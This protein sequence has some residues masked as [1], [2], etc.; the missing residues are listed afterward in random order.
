M[1]TVAISDAHHEKFR[2]YCENAVRRTQKQQMELMIEEKTNWHPKG[3][4]E[5]VTNDEK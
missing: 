2:E 1:R 4:P 3:K 5:G